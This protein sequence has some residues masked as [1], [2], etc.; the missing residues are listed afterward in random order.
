MTE[1]VYSPLANSSLWSPW[2]LGQSQS[3]FQAQK[4]KGLF[5]CEWMHVTQAMIYFDLDNI[6]HLTLRGSSFVHCVSR[7]LSYHNSDILL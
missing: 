6:S 3:V 7:W 1:F 5:L 4:M 2:Q